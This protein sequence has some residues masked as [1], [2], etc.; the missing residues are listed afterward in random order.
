MT[1]GSSKKEKQEIEAEL[2]SLREENSLLK[3]QVAEWQDKES[4][5]LNKIISLQNIVES[6]S[7]VSIMITD[8]QGNILLWNKGAENMLGYS[9]EEIIEK[10]KISILYPDDGDTREVVKEVVTHLL[11]EKKGITCEVE[12]VH[13][14]GHKLWVRLTLSPRF[15]EHGEVI[16]I[17]GIGENATERKKAEA[18]LAER[19]TLAAFSAKVGNALVESASMRQV[20]CRC[21]EITSHYLGICLARVWIIYKGENVLEIQAEASGG[22]TSDPPVTSGRMEKDP[23]GKIAAGKKPFLSHQASKDP[24]LQ[25]YSDWLTR[26]AG[27]WGLSLGTRTAG[28]GVIRSVLA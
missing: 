7:A 24:N 17:L 15:N 6:P 5:W 20:L 13:K 10:E 18:A 11:N 26:E 2:D 8:L 27:L 22:L 19:V 4:R 16:G 9:A 21:S 3:K 12:E 23:L 14:D 1:L 28:H 25:H